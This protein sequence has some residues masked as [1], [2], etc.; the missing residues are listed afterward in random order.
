MLMIEKFLLRE[1]A[2]RETY[3]GLSGCYYLPDTDMAH[4]LKGMERH[5]ALQDSHALPYVV[6]IRSEFQIVENLEA[7][8]SEFAQLFVGP[9][10]LLAPPY[11]SVYL[12]GERRI[13]GDST[14]DASNRYRDSGLTTSESFRDPPD[15]IAAELE[16]MYFLVFSEIDAIQSDHT[17]AGC[18]YLHRQ[19]LFLQDHLGAW[20]ED[21]T[22]HVEQGTKSDFYRN[23]AI[24]TRIYIAEDFEY[25]SNLRVC[26]AMTGHH[27]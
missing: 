14:V 24:A 9:Y 20:I 2:R 6:L 16:F 8:Q 5:L 11:G 13:M 3:K 4:R 22:C 23:L 17:N 12:E 21:F 15:H 25:L 18:D 26:Q 7:H 19:K 1:T 27:S 10:S